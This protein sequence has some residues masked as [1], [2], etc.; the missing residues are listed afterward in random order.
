MNIE[1]A[2][3]LG[4]DLRDLKKDHTAISDELKEQLVTACRTFQSS[5]DLVSH[6]PVTLDYFAINYQTCS[7]LASIA[8][9]EFMAQVALVKMKNPPKKPHVK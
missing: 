6:F 5:P 1:E 9:Y 2:M 3:K 4:R 8:L 7:F